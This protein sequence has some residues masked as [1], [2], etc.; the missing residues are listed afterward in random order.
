MTRTALDLTREGPGPASAEE[1]Y[2]AAVSG[3]AIAM[4]TF[5]TT[6]RYL[7]IACANLINLLNPQA[8]VIGGGV[9]GSG[10]FLLQPAIEEARRRA[11]ASAFRDCSIVQ[12][13]LWPDSGL[14]GAAM[15]ARDR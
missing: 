13:L 15:L 11:F 6:G 7:G 5:A 4:E 8:I 10:D 9:M 1:I 14:I 3:D 12:S 2:H